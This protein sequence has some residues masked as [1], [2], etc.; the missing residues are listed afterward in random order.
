MEKFI[1]GIIVV[2]LVIFIFAFLGAFITQF[3][4]NHSLVELYG[5]KEISFFQAW[6]LNMLGGMVCKSSGSSSK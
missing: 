4:Y 5:V 1:G 6:C 2:F 3:A